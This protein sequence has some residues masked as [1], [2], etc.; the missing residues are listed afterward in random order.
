MKIPLNEK[1]IKFFKGLT[2]KNEIKESLDFQY[3][4]CNA[5]FECFIKEEKEREI[6]LNDLMYENLKCANYQTKEINKILRTYK[7]KIIVESVNIK[8]NIKSHFDFLEKTLVKKIN[9]KE[10][11]QE[12]I[13]T[14]A[15][16]LYDFKLYYDEKNQPQYSYRKKGTEQW[17]ESNDP[18]L[19][20]EIK[21]RVKFDGTQTTESQPLTD[22]KIEKKVKKIGLDR[23]FN[24]M[25]KALMS[26]MGT[27]VQRFLSLTGIGAVAT[28][29]LWGV[30]TI[31][32]AYKAL[33]GSGSW[34]NLIIDLLCLASNGYLSKFLKPLQGIVSKTAK[35]AIDY[36]TKS[37]G[38][39]KLVGKFL[40]KI[41][42]KYTNIS[43]L[44]QMGIDWAN[45]KLK[46]DLQSGQGAIDQVTAELKNTPVAT[47]ESFLLTKKELI[48]QKNIYK[49]N[50]YEK[51]FK[52]R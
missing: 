32:D 50:E 1:Q 20:T 25:R 26:P 42:E 27:L 46:T 22:E 39:G 45:K 29:V 49:K 16:G 44:I 33:T 35:Q 40:P 37:S 5:M 14:V 10:D 7:S 51:Y 31:Y 6:Y 48:E 4:V 9:L 17:Y 36:I 21:N 19:D 41:V 15:N 47:K 28:T 38:L 34:M 13:N 52:F 8:E 18:E 2:E 24:G 43:N 3:R 30:L 12:K 11:T 23:F